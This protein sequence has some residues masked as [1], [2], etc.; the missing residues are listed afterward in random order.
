MEKTK[1]L[2]QELPV[3]ARAGMLRAQAY[4]VD[5]DVVR[6]DFA[7]DQLDEL[8]TT[9]SEKSVELSKL[10]DEKKAFVMEIEAK[11][12]PVKLEVGTAVK[13]LRNRFS[14]SEEEVFMLDNQEEGTMEI[15]DACGKF[16]SSRRLRPSEKQLQIGKNQS[17]G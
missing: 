9:I 2:F 7:P 17:N 10:V 5:I 12:K 4:A 8:K 1:D 11:I 16:L 3:E 15:Y 14:E 13:K 6:R